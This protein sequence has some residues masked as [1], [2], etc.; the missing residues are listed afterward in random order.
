MA[1]ATYQSN[2][3]ETAVI[4]S[5]EEP[6]VPER[7]KRLRDVLYTAPW[8]L[9]VDRMKYYTE[10]Y[11]ETEGELPAIRAA[12]GL[13]RTLSR[14]TVRIDDD[15]LIVGAKSSKRFSAPIYIEGSVGDV[16]MLLALKHCKSG[17]PLEK[18]YPQ[19]FM[20]V[21][22]ELL[23][24]LP[25][26][27]EDEYRTITEE[28]LPYW[29]DKTIRFRVRQR[30]EQV[31]FP[32]DPVASAL[33]M[34]VGSDPKEPP[35]PV[36]GHVSVGLRK[37]LKIGL[38]GIARQAAERLAKLDPN[39]ENY[40]RQKDFLEAVQVSAK[41]V[42][43]FAERYAKL[44]EETAVKAEPE[45][46]SELLEIAE[47]CRRVPGDPPR[48]LLE[49]IQSAY[50]VQAAVLI[51]YGDNSITCPG[52]MDQYLYP[53][54]R[55]DLKAGKITRKQALEAVM[56]YYIK[57]AYTFNGPNVFTIGGIDRQGENA[58]NEM[59]YLFLEAHRN[60][61]GLRN[62][63]G[64]RI[65]EK[66]SHEF[67][68]KAC[69]VHRH[70][71]GVAFFND[72]VVVRDLMTDGYSLEDARDWCDIGCTETT[73]TANNNGNTAAQ[74]TFHV[75]LLEMALNEG[76]WSLIGWKRAGLQTPPV[77]T[78]KNFEDVKRAF[79]EQVAHCV[80]TAVR[81]IELKERV[82]AEY[83]PQPLLSSTIE[84]CVESAT[85]ITAGGAKYNSAAIGNQ[86]LATQAD[87]LTAIKWAVFD[88]KL[89]TMDELVRHLRNNF[90]GAEEVRQQLLHA[91][92]FGNDDP[93]ADEMAVW[94]AQN[95][96]NELRKHKYW[97]GG[98][99]RGCLISA[100]SQDVEGLIC[101]ATPDG[102]LAKAAVSNGM[103]PTNSMER[104]GMTAALCSGAKASIVPLSDGTSFNININPST[105]KTDEGLEKFANIIEAY[106]ALGGRNVQFNPVS[107]AMLLDAQ[108]HPEN[109]PEL[110]VKVSGFS[111]RFIDLPKRLQND[112]IARTEFASC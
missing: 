1:T 79:T 39:E 22:P 65:S 76:G 107:A 28:I 38:K 99:H 3:A 12:K 49:A 57:V 23:K 82:I 74:P 43:N 103:S 102:R 80:D 24:G 77:S 88:K 51:S 36:Q 73:G 50:L 37:V 4:A 66:T 110:M 8:E 21:S 105:I 92:K 30:M 14:M 35:V 97:M 72:A 87:S 54:Y 32:V 7:I 15:E 93:D 29:R 31:G 112:I 16:Y 96:S 61:K 60:L 109:Y 104:N 64:V 52:R 70:T 90:A 86:A 20:G 33:A 47:R 62:A 19:G 75:V 59:S 42:C 83:Y 55:E 58:A 40:A 11:K 6:Y 85:D 18:A 13:E 25:N 44:A 89:L 111:F 34:W 94:V 78:F 71:A 2:T 45:R 10:S 27:S 108:E 69:E 5:Q 100:L 106:F 81:R 26:L 56:E 95:F 53:F 84:G 67:L 17:E 46:R 101:G 68:L 98:V 41:A 91:P 48:N 63:L 9:D